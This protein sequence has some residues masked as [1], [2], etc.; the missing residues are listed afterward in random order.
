[1]SVLANAPEGDFES[2]PHLEDSYKLAFVCIQH[3]MGN[4]TFELYMS[5]EAPVEG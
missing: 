2:D 4:D 5:A 3:R 1:M